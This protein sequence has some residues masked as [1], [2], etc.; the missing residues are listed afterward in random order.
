MPE[1]LN[2]ESIKSWLR[3]RSGWK[4]KGD[5]MVKEFTFS[6]F[7]DAIVFVNRVATIADE[8]DHHPDIDIRY[9]T[10][11]LVLSTHHAGGITSKDLAVAEQIDFATSTR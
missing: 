1:K 8:A 4:R 6:S 3:D 11:R 2:E 7:R 10:V 9:T 5:A